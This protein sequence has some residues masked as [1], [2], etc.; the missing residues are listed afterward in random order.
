M[1]GCPRSPPG[2]TPAAVAAD[3]ISFYSIVRAMQP[4]GPPDDTRMIE[5]ARR[6]RSSSS[7]KRP[8]EDSD[9]RSPRGDG[10]DE[11]SDEESETEDATVI[12]TWEPTDSADES[13]GGFQQY[14]FGG[15]LYI[16]NWI[17]SPF[18][19]RIVQKKPAKNIHE[20]ACEHIC[21]LF[22]SVYADRSGRKGDPCDS[23]DKAA[24][25]CNSVQRIIRS[26]SRA[27]T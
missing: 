4:A 27:G 25:L 5:P 3:I 23:I 10:S 1:T 18:S 16:E 2:S 6:S 24:C 17:I 7:I 11:T 21:R 9:E 13:L 12:E 19:E 8:K 26:Q 22:D 14:I 15:D 20:Q